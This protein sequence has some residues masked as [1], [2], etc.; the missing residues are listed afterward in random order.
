MKYYTLLLVITLFIMSC[1]KHQKKE[2]GE[3]DIKKEVLKAYNSMYNSYAKGTDDFFKYYEDDFLRV[4]TSG[5]LNRGVKKR[6]MEWNNY[7]KTHSVV[8]ENFD[9]PEMIISPQQVITIGD[10]SEYFIDQKTKDSIYNRGVYIAAWKKQ[11]DGSWKIGMDTW[12]AGLD[13]E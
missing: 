13:K 4:E 2:E 8:L 7:L 1:A 3:K 9:Q 11:K 10:F 12:H 6:K 5:K